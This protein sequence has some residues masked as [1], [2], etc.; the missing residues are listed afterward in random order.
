VT[1]AQTAIP[2][3]FD[4]KD[5]CDRR[6]YQPGGSTRP[7]SCVS[8]GD[9]SGA[10]M[11][12]VCIDSETANR[13]AWEITVVLATGQTTMTQ[14]PGTCPGNGGHTTMTLTTQTGLSD[15]ATCWASP[16]ALTACAADRREPRGRR[17][18]GLR[19]EIARSRLHVGR[20]PDGVGDHRARGPRDDAVGSGLSTERPG[21]RV[22]RPSGPGRTLGGTAGGQP[23]GTDQVVELRRRRCALLHTGRRRMGERDVRR[24]HPVGGLRSPHPTL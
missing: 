18:R 9:A 22:R 6:A 17:A 20:V 5:T 2:S 12:V 24:H 1:V 16:Y 10:T 4:L 21:A 23:R 11:E 8:A 7:P 15:L 19:V 14:Y 13:Y 3:S